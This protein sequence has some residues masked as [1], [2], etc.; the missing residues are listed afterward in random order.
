MSR[1]LV[2]GTTLTVLS[3]AMLAVGFNNCSP[4]FSLST[5]AVR[6]FASKC[7]PSYKGVST[8]LSSL[9]LARTCGEIANYQCDVR[10]FRPGIGSSTVTEPTCL[11]TPLG[12]K[13]LSVTITRFDTS[14]NRSLPSVPSDAFNEGGSLNYSESSCF[15]RMVLIDGISAFHSEAATLEEAL[16]DVIEKCQNGSP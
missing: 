7:N 5:N 4:S 14:S 1:K 15:N 8:D 16:S 11:S 13:C 6:A 9:D 12:Q 10:E 2:L 3:S